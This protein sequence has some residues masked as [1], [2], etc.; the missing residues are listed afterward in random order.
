MCTVYGWQRCLTIHEN[1]HFVLISLP[2][3]VR[4]N[5]YSKTTVS[6]ELTEQCVKAKA[7]SQNVE[8]KD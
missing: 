4:L 8:G 2:R 6:K 3:P 1:F 7:F 5:C